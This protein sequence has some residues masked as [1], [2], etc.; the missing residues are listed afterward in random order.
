MYF[1]RVGHTSPIY[2][3]P[4]L[5]IEIFIAIIIGIGARKLMTAPKKACEH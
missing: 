3:S 1:F 2:K 4:L 5:Y